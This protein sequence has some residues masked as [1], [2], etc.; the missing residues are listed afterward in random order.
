LSGSGVYFVKVLDYV[1]IGYTA[2]FSVRL[3]TIT[4]AMPVTPEVLAFIEGPR[5]I[6]TTLHRMLRSVCLKNEWYADG[7]D[8]REVLKRTLAGEIKATGRNDA[9][10]TRKLPE[11]VVWASEALK[12]IAAPID[13]DE[14]FNAAVGRAAERA[15]LAYWRTFD[16]WYAKARRLGPEERVAIA[17][18]LEVANV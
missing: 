1:K 8:V 11:D 5:S 2:D 3:D 18:A 17:A 16:L 13:R 12:Q 15:N 14:S 9:G 6:E 7:P 4:R 10:K